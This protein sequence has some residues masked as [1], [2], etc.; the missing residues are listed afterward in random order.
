MLH[1][2]EERHDD[3][4]RPSVLDIHEFL[5]L[6][7]LGESSDPDTS[8]LNRLPLTGGSLRA[9]V[10]RHSERTMTVVFPGQIEAITRCGICPKEETRP[11]RALR[12]L[13]LPYAHHPAYR[14]EWRIA[15]P[16]A[17]SSIAEADPYPGTEELALLPQQRG[18]DLPPPGNARRRIL[19]QFGISFSR[20][21]FTDEE[22]A[23]RGMT[24]GTP[25]AGPPE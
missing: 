23:R 20:S 17:T 13:A 8:D 21:D 3:T 9:A 24:I 25:A 2:L 12:I 4:R 19:R 18:S 15:E 14:P 16:D 10:E 6:Y 5:L 22:L 7:V 1:S 11:C